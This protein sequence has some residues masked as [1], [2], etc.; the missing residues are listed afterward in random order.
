MSNN[1]ELSTETENFNGIVCYRVRAIRNIPGLGIFKG[2]LGGWVQSLDNVEDNAVIAGNARATGNAVVKDNAVIQDDVI[3][4]GNAVVKEESMI[5]KS[6]IIDDDAVIS[7]HAYI[8]DNV[9]IEN[10]AEVG[11]YAV[12]L[13]DVKIRGHACVNGNVFISQ[14]GMILDGDTV[15]NEYED[16][17]VNEVK[18]TEMYLVYET[19]DGQRHF[20][21]WEDSDGATI[22]GGVLIGWTMKPKN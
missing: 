8:S 2:D 15:I 1:Y 9:L 4:R 16:I 12:V 17:L 11:E 14:E 5:S 6:A 21:H 22:N 18:T 3:V 19:E 13:N 7:G 10:N 20:L